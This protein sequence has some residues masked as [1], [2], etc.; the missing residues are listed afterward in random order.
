MGGEARQ[1]PLLIEKLLF[2][3]PIHAEE[4]NLL[5]LTFILHVVYD[6][7]LYRVSAYSIYLYVG[8]HHF[9]KQIALDA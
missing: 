9:L 2:P 7:L 4:N 6:Q 3:S 5:L 1:V 8:I